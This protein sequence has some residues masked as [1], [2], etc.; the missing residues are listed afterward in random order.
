MVRPGSSCR[1]SPD[2]LACEPVQKVIQQLVDFLSSGDL[3]IGGPR[4]ELMSVLKG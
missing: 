1:F 2:L 4:F 3:R